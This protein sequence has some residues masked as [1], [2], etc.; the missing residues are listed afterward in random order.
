MTNKEMLSHVD[1]TQLKPFATWE[2]IERLCDEAIQYETASV[3]VPPAYIKRIADKY[4]DKLNICTV[5]GFPLG[6]SV[7]AAKEAEIDQALRDGAN[8]ID[9]VVNI[10]DVKNHRFAQVEEEIRT[11][12][13]ACKGHILKVI[14]ETCFLTE[15]EKIAMCKAVTN[16]GADYIK[17]STGFGT[18]GATMEDVLLFKKHIGPAVK[19]K[20][21]GGVKTRDDLEAFLTAGCDRIGTSSAVGIL[22]GEEAKGY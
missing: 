21:A 4:G 7:T 22:K 8:E 6:Y 15:E 5:V 17:T 14:I 20:A 2:D 13:A 16:A 3:C 11:L 10:S 1:H 18:G 19:I 9:M 12:K